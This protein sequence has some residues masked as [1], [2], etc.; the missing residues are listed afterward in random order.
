[1]GKHGAGEL[2]VEN[3]FDDDDEVG[4]ER[5]R[6]VGV[7]CGNVPINRDQLRRITV[8]QPVQF[9]AATITRVHRDAPITEFGARVQNEGGRRECLGSA[10]NLTSCSV[11]YN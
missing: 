6:T 4:S 5:Q 9:P 3:G 11:P 1:M 7:Q 2:A 8:S 10:A